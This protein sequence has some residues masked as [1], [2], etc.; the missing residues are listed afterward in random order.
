[1]AAA[2]ARPSGT[3][4][5]APAC[6]SLDR[7][8]REVFSGTVR[9]TALMDEAIHAGHDFSANSEVAV[10]ISLRTSG[11]VRARE[12]VARTGMTSA[13]TT[14]MVDRLELAGLA[15][16]SLD[17]HDRRGVFVELTPSGIEAVDA[18]TDRVTEALIA[19]APLLASWGEYFDAMGFDVGPLRLPAGSVRKRLEYVR[20]M[21]SAG[22]HLQP[23]YDDAFGDGVP[24]PRL[25]LLVLLLATESGGTRPSRVREAALLSSASTSDLLGRAEGA[26]LV[27]RSCGRPPDRRATIVAAT[28]R[29]RAAL[30]IVLDGSAPVMRAL[31]ETYFPN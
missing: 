14:N 11:R 20:R 26:G 21:T 12:L 19:A 17:E 28:E 2:P 29:G 10:L 9:L 18:M 30:D 16:R 25:L 27:T 23:L 3:L 13:G 4:V 6:A 24:K 22:P 15:R 7:A 8:R 31:A 1:M 5:R